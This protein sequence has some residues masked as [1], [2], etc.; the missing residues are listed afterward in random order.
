MTEMTG[1]PDSAQKMVERIYSAA[2]PGVVYSA[3]VVA[4][5][6]TVITA[7]EVAAGGGFGFGQGH[8][9]ADAGQESTQRSGGVG[10]GGGGGGGRSMGRPVAVNPSARSVSASSRSWTRPR[11]PWPQSPRGS[12]LPRQPSVCA[13]SAAVAEPARVSD[14]RV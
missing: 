6:Y 4:G 11:S 1:I 14:R 12:Q 2:Q 7:S 9:P 3:P 8:G 10:G 5:S 13:G